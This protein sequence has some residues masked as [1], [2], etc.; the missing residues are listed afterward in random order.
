MV[1]LNC[2]L[3]VQK[4]KT[5]IPIGEVNLKQLFGQCFTLSSLP[6]HVTLIMPRT[7]RT[8]TSYG[9]VMS[10]AGQLHG[11]LWTV[12]TTGQHVQGIHSN[13]V[14]LAIQPCIKEVQR[15]HQP[16]ATY[17]AITRELVL[18]EQFRQSLICKN[19]CFIS[20]PITS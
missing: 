2:V 5:M 10:S 16:W 19:Y 11:E 9:A 20:I 14:F 8:V 17:P 7:T 1:I 13:T 3:L 4:Q 15:G 6:N 18:V 12:C